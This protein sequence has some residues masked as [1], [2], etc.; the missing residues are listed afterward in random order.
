VLID[1]WEETPGLLRLSA[2][3]FVERSGQKAILIGARGQK[4][5]QIATAARKELEAR[6]GRKIFLEVFVKVHPKWR[7][8]SSFLRSL[9]YREMIGADS[10]D[11]EF[12]E[13]PSAK[14]L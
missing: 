12:E 3:V 14:H 4:M 1:N 7:D 10:E 2:T 6:F 11:F 9:D 8:R 5:K 13:E